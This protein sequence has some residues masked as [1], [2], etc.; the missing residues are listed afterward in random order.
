MDAG[1]MLACHAGIFQR[2]AAM[3]NGRSIVICGVSGAASL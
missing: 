3:G 2:S 1:M